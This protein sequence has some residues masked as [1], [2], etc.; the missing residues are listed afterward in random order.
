[1]NESFFVFL[2]FLVW[3][4]GRLICFKLN[5]HLFGK[6]SASMSAW[7]CVWNFLLF[8]WFAPCYC[9]R[10]CRWMR[11]RQR[12]LWRSISNKKGAYFHRS[13]S[14]FVVLFS[15]PWNGVPR[16]SH[17]SNRE[18]IFKQNLY[19]FRQ[20]M[21]ISICVQTS[22]SSI[23]RCKQCKC[24][25]IVECLFILFNSVSKQ[26]FRTF[27]LWRWISLFAIHWWNANFMMSN[28]IRSKPV[29][30]QQRTQHTF[31]KF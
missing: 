19:S 1:M 11:V 31:G 30:W 28:R 13:H 5:R 15:M 4:L 9:C 21:P 27:G 18:S 6:L 29:K 16:E 2:V 10:Q 22:K 20:Q 17:L 8:H 14:I 12:P 24:L 23:R 3:M 25:Q 7:V 26:C